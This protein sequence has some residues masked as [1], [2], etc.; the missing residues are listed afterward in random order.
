[1]KNNLS[2]SD[3]KNIKTM[4]EKLVMTY[5]IANDSD[6]KYVIGVLDHNN[7]YSNIMKRLEIAIPILDE[8]LIDSD[9]VMLP[10]SY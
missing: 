9:E 7:N 4:L 8:M 6:L 3:L 1:M 10:I 2:I 5:Q